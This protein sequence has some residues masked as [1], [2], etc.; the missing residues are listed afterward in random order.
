MNPLRNS[1]RAGFL[2]SCIPNVIQDAANEPVIGMNKGI[3][4]ETDVCS[5]I[6]LAGA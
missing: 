3:K 6:A 1:V 4:G 5:I 2:F